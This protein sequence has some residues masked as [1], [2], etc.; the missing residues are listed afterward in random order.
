VVAFIDDDCEASPAWLEEGLRAAR[1]HPGA[2]VQGRT[3]PLPRERDRLGP[4]AHTKSV[5]GPTPWFTTCNILYPREVLEAVGG[6][7]EG[8]KQAGEDVD[9]GWRATENGAGHEFAAGALAYHAVEDL[10]PLG[11]LRKALRGAD[12]TLFYRR[13]PELRARYAYRWFFR[14]PSHAHLILAA[15]GL[16]LARR[17]RPALLLTLPYARG[18]AGR[19]RELG[20]S[21]V[22][23]PYFVLWD[24][25][26]VSTAVR[27]SIRYRILLL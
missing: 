6:F 23:V 16:A 21:P 25:L 26:H 18:L 10:G 11:D 17:W 2:I 1:E 13:H 14:R 8:F 15:T 24:A 22:I 9:L 12:S 7:D 27:G 19:C 5:G 20:A 3:E 4:F